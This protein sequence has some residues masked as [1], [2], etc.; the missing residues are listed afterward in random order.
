M[1]IDIRYL[2]VGWVVL[3]SIL[4]LLYLF[5]RKHTLVSRNLSSYLPLGFCS[6]MRRYHIDNCSFQ[7][8]Q[9]AVPNRVAR[10]QIKGQE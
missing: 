9:P 7:L 1:K 8:Q 5:N 10:F 2:K 4:L 6:E 3:L